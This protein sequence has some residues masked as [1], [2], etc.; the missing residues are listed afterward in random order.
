ML[1]P[2]RGEFFKASRNGNIEVVDRLLKEGFDPSTNSNI[3]IKHASQNGHVE[4]VKRLLDDPR[5][6]PSADGNIAIK[7]ASENGHVEVVEFLE[8]EI[9]ERREKEDMSGDVIF[10][11]GIKSLSG[12]VSFY[13]LRP[14][15]QVYDDGNGK[16]FPL[17]VL[18]GDVHFSLEGTCDPCLCDSDTKTCC[19][20]LSDPEF[21]E[22]IDTLADP[23]HPVDFYTETFLGG[24]GGGFKGGML[25][26]LTTGE[27]LSCYRKDYEKCPTKNIR[28]QAG[29]ARHAGDNDKNRKKYIEYQ[30]YQIMNSLQHYGES[31]PNPENLYLD[32]FYLL[33]KESPI[34]VF[35]IESLK[36]LLLTLIDSEDDRIN[37]QNFANA[38]FKL[39]TKENSLIYKQ[40]V[41]QNYPP[42]RDLKEWPDFFRRSMEFHTSSRYLSIPK[43]KQIIQNLQNVPLILHEVH[44]RND[45]F[46]IVNFLYD[47]AHAL[48]DIY[49]IARIWKQPDGGPRSSL[50]FCYFGNQHVLNIAELLLSTNAYELVLEMPAKTDPISRCQTFDF[51]LNL[52]EEVRKHNEIIRRE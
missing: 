41:K 22:K 23:L 11:G 16:Y 13:Y 30:F 18:F 6:D 45:I 39:C 20:K 46:F 21:L 29:D 50:S 33:L 32:F 49:T 44:H 48:L 7:L 4:V 27:M 10:G 5:V 1:D 12:P 31:Y 43:L 15:K 8:R 42:F 38:F 28:W 19:Y 37:F 40:I 3:S 14:K 52:T 35:N 9:R 25:D 26:D 17:I 51:R 24:T 34:N 47:I 36:A 2:R